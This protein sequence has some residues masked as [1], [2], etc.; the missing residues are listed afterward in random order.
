MRSF[1]FLILALE[2]LPGAVAGVAG[3]VVV[4]LILMGRL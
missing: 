3:V 4:V 2:R 1:L